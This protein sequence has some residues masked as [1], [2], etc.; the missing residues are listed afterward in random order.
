MD[1]L[2][3]FGWIGALSY[4]IAYFL[5]V[6]RILTAQ[7]I[8]YH[9]L[10]AFGGICLVINASILIDPPNIVVNTVWVG[11]A[12]YALINIQRRKSPDRA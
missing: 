3:I 2:S 6:V 10:N 11:L 5:L 1:I 7:D 9:A 4:I 8:A 12:V